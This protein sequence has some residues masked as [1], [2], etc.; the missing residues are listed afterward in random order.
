M[1]LTGKLSDVPG[2]CNETG[3]QDLLLMVTKTKEGAIVTKHVGVFHGIHQFSAPP[4]LFY[5]E[6]TTILFKWLIN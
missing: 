4:V 3:H 1:L 5:C 2:T 6:E